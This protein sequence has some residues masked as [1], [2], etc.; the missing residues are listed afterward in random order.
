MT[1]RYIVLLGA[2]AL[3]VLV[4]AGCSKKADT[5]DK[6]SNDKAQISEEGGD[7]TESPSVKGATIEN[8]DAATSK[9]DGKGGLY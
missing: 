5:D 8:D 1:K 4:G 2:C 3:L 7:I 6:V 9:P